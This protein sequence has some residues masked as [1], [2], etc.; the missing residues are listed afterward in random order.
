MK[1]WWQDVTMGV[2]TLWVTWQEGIH[3]MLKE[4]T[5]KGAEMQ[6]VLKRLYG[7]AVTEESLSTFNE[8]LGKRFV[9][10]GDFNQRNEELKNLRSQVAGMEEELLAGR[11][12][13]LLAE[14]LRQRLQETEEKHANELAAYAEQ[15]AKKQMKSALDKALSEAGAR[16]L[17]AVK[18]LLDLEKIAFKN[19]ELTGLNEQLWDLKKENSYLFLE[20]K[21]DIQFILTLSLIIIFH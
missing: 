19:G 21:Q 17:I 1:D 6:E 5:Q 15:E 2:L 13:V 8:E 16:N 11:E 10:K 7:E 4:S 14:E 12:A 3:Q 18:A 20:N 9:A